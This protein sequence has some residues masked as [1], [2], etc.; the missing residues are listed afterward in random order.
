MTRFNR[1]AS[2]TPYAS[3]KS[4][5]P[6]I[7]RWDSVFRKPQHFRRDERICHLCADACLLHSPSF[8]L[9]SVA[10]YQACPAS[11]GDR[12]GFFQVRFQS[13]VG[14]AIKSRLVLTVQ[15]RVKRASL[16]VHTGLPDG[17]PIRLMVIG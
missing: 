1:L 13:I 6:P 5:F 2:G 15:P 12:I 3:F 4:T 17:V 16:T 14:V 10:I 8:F 7:R 11:D 9:G